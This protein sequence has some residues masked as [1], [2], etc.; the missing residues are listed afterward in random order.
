MVVRTLLGPRQ[1]MLAELYGGGFTGTLVE[2]YFFDK[3]NNFWIIAVHTLFKYFS[4]SIEGWTITLIFF[5][6]LI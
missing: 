5:V 2:P 1:R 4:I 3:K 6:C